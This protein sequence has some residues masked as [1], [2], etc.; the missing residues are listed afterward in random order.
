MFHEDYSAHFSAQVKGKSPQ[1]LRLLEIGD[2]LDY[3]HTRSNNAD[4]FSEYQTSAR[5]AGYASAASARQHRHH[6]AFR[7]P[8]QT[9][10]SGV[11]K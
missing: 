10:L 4:N 3:D 9:H 5:E 2:G 1:H 8:M 11:G 6:D 7:P